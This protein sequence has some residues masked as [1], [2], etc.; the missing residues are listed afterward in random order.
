MHLIKYGV[1]NVLSTTNGILCLCA[2]SAHF[3]K[4]ATLAN[5]FPKVSTNRAFVFSLIAA[6]ISPKL[7]GSTNVV[8]IP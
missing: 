6:S 3:S 2:I 7:S 5:G 1:A 4:S 8:L